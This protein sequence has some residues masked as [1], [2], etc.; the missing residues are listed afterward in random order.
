MCF[1]FLLLQISCWV[2]KNQARLRGDDISSCINTQ[3]IMINSLRKWTMRH[4]H[5]CTYLSDR[6]KLREFKEN[7][8]LVCVIFYQIFIFLSNERPSKAMKNVF[9]F[10][11]KSSFCSR[12]IKNYVI[13]SLP[14]H[15]F[16]V[17]KGKWK[18]NNLWCHKLACINLEM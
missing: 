5:A 1:S 10:H 14:F 17:Q 3:P 9:L 18:W 15:T 6:A 11:L 13:F 2:K 4:W 12:D 8:K 16:Q 7:L